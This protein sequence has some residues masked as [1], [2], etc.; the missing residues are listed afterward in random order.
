MQHH[1]TATLTFEHQQRLYLHEASLE[2][3]RHGGPQALGAAARARCRAEQLGSSLGPT[4]RATVS[5]F[6]DGTLATLLFSGLP[7]PDNDPL[8]ERL[9]PLEQLEQDFACL[10]LAARSQILLE[11]VHH[12]A[13]AF[14][15]DN[16]GKQV[17]L[18]GNFKGGGSQRLPDENG[19][20][21]VELSSHAGLRLGPH[22]EAPYHCSVTANDGHSPAPSALILGARWNPLGEPTCIIP[23]QAVIEKL[24]SLHVLALTSASFDFTR[25][26]C[27]VAGRGDGGN[28]TSIVQFDEH[29]GF[30]VRYNAY[31]FSLNDQA[32]DAAAQAFD[33]FQAAVMQAPTL[34][35]VLQPD[36][37]LLINNSRALHGRNV[38]RDNRRLLVR[39]FGYSRF[40]QPL[41][42]SDDPLLVRG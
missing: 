13:F 29:S 36:N 26:E 41:V 9:P 37:V 25:S 14:D 42:I 20:G 27:F 32:C 19:H 18:V 39:L 15:I 2:L 8:P 38:L 6:A 24:G 34:E 30:T 28:A 10:Y 31:R 1:E 5:L 35:F 3:A 16:E 23:L 22:T 7:H 4:Q 33:A 40:A 21:N 11:L 17:R 12:R